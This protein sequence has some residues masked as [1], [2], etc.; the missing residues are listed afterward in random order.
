[1]NIK[2]IYIMIMKEIQQLYININLQVIK[3]FFINATKGQNVM[4]EVN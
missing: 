1:M 2:I 3:I 4:E